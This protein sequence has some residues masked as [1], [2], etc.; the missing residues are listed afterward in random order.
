MRIYE[1][2]PRQD[3]EEV[4]RS[5]GRFA[6]AEGLKDLLFLER[7]DGFLL[8]GLLYMDAGVA[9]DSF[10]SLGKR[11]Y[12]LSDEKVAELMEGA[13]ESRG[14][15]AKGPDKEITNYYEMALRVIGSYLDKQR[16][17]DV[18]FLEQEG[19]F[20]V[21]LFAAGSQAGAHSLA[22]FTHEEMLAM[23]E[24]AQQ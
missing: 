24:K 22:E 10:G 4:L 20:V 14:E 7:E 23:I 18:F 11:N 21:R 17:H 16:P 13:F 6:D 2:T 12:E 8:Q 9:A 3:W 19:S 1:G 15:G 5:I